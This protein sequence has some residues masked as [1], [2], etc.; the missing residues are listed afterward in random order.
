MEFAKKVKVARVLADL[1]IEELAELVGTSYGTIQRVLTGKDGKDYPIKADIKDKICK[2]LNIEEDGKMDEK[3]LKMLLEE[4]AKRA[5]A[6][7]RLRK[8]GCLLEDPKKD[9]DGHP[10]KKAKGK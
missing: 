9:N 5:I 8:C 7:E 1:S 4:R 3:L 6:E 2:V 10:L